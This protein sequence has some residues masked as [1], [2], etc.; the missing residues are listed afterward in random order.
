MIKCIFDNYRA[1]RAVQF[2]DKCQFLANRYILYTGYSIGIDDCV[3]IPRK[4]VKSI[5]NNEFLKT[6]PLNPDEAVED[7]KNN[8]MNMSRQQ[9]NQ[10]D[11]NGF[12]SVE[13]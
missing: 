3:V 13:S 2:T 5:V 7:V 6:D 11:N 1:K 4:V 12:I 8:I 9:L 10:N